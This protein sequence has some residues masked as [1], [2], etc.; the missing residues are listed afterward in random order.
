MRSTQGK[1][2]HYLSGK[3]SAAVLGSVDVQGRGGGGGGC[4]VGVGGGGG[5]G[6]AGVVVAA[7]L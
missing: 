7:V 2:T 6:S 4:G 5:G 3:T 1:A